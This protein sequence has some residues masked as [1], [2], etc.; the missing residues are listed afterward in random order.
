MDQ[1]GCFRNSKED[2]DELAKFFSLSKNI[3]FAYSEDQIGCI[4]VSLN[5]NFTKLGVMPFGGNPTGRIWVSVYG[6]G[7]NHLS[8]NSDAKYV[9]EKLNIRGEESEWIARI[10]N[11]IASRTGDT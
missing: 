7:C 10:L 1:Y 4:I 2:F 8:Y 5:A 9:A 11:E 6:R 3:V